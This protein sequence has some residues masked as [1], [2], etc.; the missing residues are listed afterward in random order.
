MGQKCGRRRRSA[1]TGVFRDLIKPERQIQHWFASGNRDLI[2]PLG[3]DDLTGP[4]GSTRVW[5][6]DVNS[7]GKLDVLLGDSVMLVSLPDG[8][9]KEESDK[10]QAEW[11][12]NV[13]K[14]LEEYRAAAG[15]Q[16]KLR[17]AGAK[18]RKLYAQR[19]EFII[20][21]RTGFVWLYLQK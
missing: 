9:S 17:E 1:R 3:E 19:S 10:K 4:T 18:M 21:D 5:V 2:K 15:D 20:E 11:Q 14:V 8:L 12:K 7:D 16:D 13:D 6:D